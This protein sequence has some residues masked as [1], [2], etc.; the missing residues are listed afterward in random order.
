[1]VL[2][3]GLHT[4]MAL[5]STIGN[6]LDG[7]GWTTAL[8]EAQV[9]SVG[10][11]DSF[12]KA[13]H[14]TR[15]RHGHQVSLLTLHNLQQEAFMR[16]TGPKDEQSAKEWRDTMLK[17]S[18]TFMFWDH[19]MK[20]EALILIFIRAHREKNFTLY[21]KVLKELTPL[22]FALDHVNYSRWMPSCSHSRYEVPTSHCQEGV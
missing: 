15:T 20:Y 7:S 3:G 1:M 5:W 19:I 11:A 16:T 4:E 18:P 22:F 12:L 14:L 8:T 6:L 13:A 2:L 9:A 17:K 10:T 21:V